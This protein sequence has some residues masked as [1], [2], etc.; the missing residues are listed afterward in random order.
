M[1]F[2]QKLSKQEAK[3]LVGFASW[4][5]GSQDSTFLKMSDVFAALPFRYSLF[6]LQNSAALELEM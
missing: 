4:M 6:I 3:V 1:L 5:V 2:L